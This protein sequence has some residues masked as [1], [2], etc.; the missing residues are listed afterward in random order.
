MMLS[1]LKHLQYWNQK[2]KYFH[3]L[4]FCGFLDFCKFCDLSIVLESEAESCHFA[5]AK[6]KRRRGIKSHWVWFL[7][8][9]AALCLPR[10]FTV[11]HIHCVVFKAFRPS[12][13]TKPQWGTIRAISSHLYGAGG[14]QNM[15]MAGSKSGYSDR[16]VIQSGDPTWNSICGRMVPHH[17]TIYVIHLLVLSVWVYA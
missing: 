15:A 11:L 6:R 16:P 8:V 13:Q 14:V 1:P 2:S 12:T 17:H 3:R 10:I 7:A 5:F 9:L 4:K